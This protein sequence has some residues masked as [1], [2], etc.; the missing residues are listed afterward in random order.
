MK[1][2]EINS[3]TKINPLG[4]EI[5]FGFDNNQNEAVLLLHGFGGKSTNWR[6]AAEKIN[7]NLGY[8]VY[9][10]RLPGHATNTEDFLNSSAEQWLR[11]AIDS[12]LYLK[13]TFK[14]IYLAG[15]SMG[16]LLAALIASNFKVE[17][18]SLIAPA[19]FAANKNIVFSPYFKY[20]IKKLDKDFEIDKENLSKEEINYH[21]NYSFHYY[22]KT[23]AELYKLMK[24]GRKAVKKINTSTQVILTKNDEQIDTQKIKSFLNK[25]MGQFL[26][27]QKIYQKSS[28]VIINDGEKEKCAKDI[29]SF[30]S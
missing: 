25:N 1:I 19:F 3:S 11:K 29:I 21:N 4:Q 28:H 2:N 12:Y 30:F 6:Y 5:K 16:G 10:P 26:V 7:Q 22:P 27:D 20:F 9:I 23:L 8:T 15:L 24:K 13:S 14:N 18:L 17:K